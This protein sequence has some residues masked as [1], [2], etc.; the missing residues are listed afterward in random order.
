MTAIRKPKKSFVPRKYLPWLDVIAIATW[1]ILMLKYC[2]TGKIYLLI[3]RDYF[4]L[5]VFGGVSL[6]LIAFFKAKQLLQRRRQPETS[7]AEHMNVFPPGGG[8]LILLVTAMMGLMITPQVFASDKAMTRSVTELLG[9]ARSQPQSFKSSRRPE[10]RTLLDWVRTLSVYPEPDSYKG[11]KAKIQGFVVH[12]SELNKD[13]IMLSQ[14]VITCCAADAY[15]I[16]LPVKIKESRDNYPPDTWLEIEG[17]MMTE[18]IAGKRHL[19]VEATS[20]KKIS[21]PKNPYSY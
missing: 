16:G 5:V 3:H 8:S 10:E 17:K 4:W 14:F 11:Q 12:Q 18:T 9:P 20:I 2:I 7:D 13:F 6:S 1:G 15:P 21:Q 19:A